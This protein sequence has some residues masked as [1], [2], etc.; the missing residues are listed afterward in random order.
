M[1][2]SCIILLLFIS[3]A[4]RFKAFYKPKEEKRRTKGKNVTWNALNLLQTDDERS[5]NSARLLLADDKMVMPRMQLKL[6][7]GQFMNEIFDF[8]LID[9]MKSIF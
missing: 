6:F 8:D 7:I 4:L 3:V 5:E 9:F 1:I 2:F